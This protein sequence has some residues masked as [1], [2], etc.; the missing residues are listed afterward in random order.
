MEDVKEEIIQG[1]IEDSVEILPWQYSCPSH[2]N[3]PAWKTITLTDGDGL[4]ERYC[5]YCIREKMHGL[6][7]KPCPPVG[8]TPY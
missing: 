2:G 1:K 7:I 4:I 6:G 8:G 5:L 3:L